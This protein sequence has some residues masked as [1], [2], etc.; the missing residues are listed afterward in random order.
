MW[1]TLYSGTVFLKFEALREEQQSI[2]SVQK[3]RLKNIELFK[4][5]FY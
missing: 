1:I 3:K 5:L 4:I 2:V